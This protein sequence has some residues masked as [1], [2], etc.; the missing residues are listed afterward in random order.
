M[1]YNLSTFGYCSSN[2]LGQ[3]LGGKIV[4]GILVSLL[5]QYGVDLEGQIKDEYRQLKTDKTSFLALY[6]AYI[7]LKLT[8]FT[9]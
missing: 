5:G 7:E 4:R 9:P 2:Y 6:L 3:H 1:K 8:L